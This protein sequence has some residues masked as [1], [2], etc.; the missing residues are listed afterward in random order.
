MRDGRLDALQRLRAIDQAQRRSAIRRGVPPCARGVGEKQDAMHV[1]KILPI[2]LQRLITI[3]TETG[4]ADAA[5]L[6]CD[7]HKALLVVC[8]RVGVM[9]GV[10]T[11]TDIVRRVADSQGDLAT[12]RTADV[13]T[14][15]V[16]VCKA[17][18]RLHDVLT[19]MKDRG[20]VHIPIVD[21]GSRPLGVVNV[22]DALQFLL[23]ELK[24]D[25]LLLRE[26]I[27]GIGYR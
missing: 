26:Y 15:V 12:V 22:R 27:M 11:K 24:Q 20:F 8:D 19:M 3:D 23:N 21:D 7:T 10:I 14:K 9:R 13:M 1:E 6:L 18:D 4:L 16:T 17:S 2:A 5:K 25:E